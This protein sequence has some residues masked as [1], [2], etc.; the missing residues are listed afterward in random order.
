MANQQK[1][2]RFLVLLS[3]LRDL[4]IMSHVVSDTNGVTD[5]FV[6]D[7]LNG[8][9]QRVSIG[10]LSN[11][12]NNQSMLPAIS[13]DGRFAA[14]QSVATN[15]IEYDTNNAADIFVRDRGS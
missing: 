7:R 5:I 11:E 6:R 1:N 8:T 15:L 14:F 4:M 9:T 3:M 13:S 2:T 12:A 10:N